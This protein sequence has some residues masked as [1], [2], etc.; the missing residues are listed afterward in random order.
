MALNDSI[1]LGCFGSINETG[2]LFNGGTVTRKS[3]VA[4]VTNHSTYEFLVG[5]AKRKLKVAPHRVPE[6]RLQEEGISSSNS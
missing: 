4:S 3:R 6:N 5:T 2:Y 1:Q